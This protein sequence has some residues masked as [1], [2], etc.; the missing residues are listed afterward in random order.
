MAWHT[1]STDAT[2]AGVFPPLMTTLMC[3]TC[4]AAVHSEIW[5]AYE[6]AFFCSKIKAWEKKYIVV[7]REE[8]GFVWGKKKKQNQR[9]TYRTCRSWSCLKEDNTATHAFL[10]R[11][12]CRN[13][14]IENAGTV[15][16]QHFGVTWKWM[17]LFFAF[18]L[19]SYFSISS[20][21]LYLWGWHVL[22][23]F[24][25]I[26]KTM[27]QSHF[28]L[29]SFFYTS[30]VIISQ[31]SKQSCSFPLWGTGFELTVESDVW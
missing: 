4:R 23:F 8:T 29:K 13:W 15:W 27:L 12:G 21:V 22:F 30:T 24:S 18:P 14:S 6:R 11:L 3:D 17:W 7:L 20:G 16:S 5:H 9:D 26:L 28:P 10:F 19:L 25:L 2:L 31:I 1:K